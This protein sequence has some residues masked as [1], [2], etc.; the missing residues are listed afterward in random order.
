MSG[1]SIILPEL[2]LLAAALIVLFFPKSAAGSRRAACCAGL[3]TAVALIYNLLMVPVGAQS[4]FGSLLRYDVYS[5]MARSFI[6]A[7]TLIWLIW[8]A[9]RAEAR[10][11]E[12]VSLVLF[13]SLGSLVLT[14]AQDLIMMLVSLE[15]S[16]LPLYVL[17]GYS[18]NSVRGL[19]G[20]LKYFLFSVL[21]TMV[22]L[23][24]L[25]FVYGAAGSTSYA[26][27]A[28]IS[29]NRYM[30]L[31][32][33]LCLV[34]FF[35]KLSAAPFHFWAPDAF[36][37]ASSWIVAFVST[38]PKIS[39][40]VALIRFVMAFDTFM[41]PQL[42]W[43]IAAVASVSMVIGNLAALKQE[44]LKRMMA[45]S[46]IAH[47]GY[48]LLAV[49][50]LNNYVGAALIYIVVYSV[51]TL[52]IMLI[53]QE[54][55][56]TLEHFKGLAKSRPAT[57]WAMVVMLCSLIGIP[58]LAGFFGKLYLF[59]GALQAN[60]LV[61]VVLALIMS[62]V[63]CVYYLRVVYVMFFEQAADDPKSKLA[64][65]YDERA[66]LPF[67]EDL[68]TSGFATTR[69]SFLSSLA[70]TI[71]VLGTVALGLGVS[72]LTAVVM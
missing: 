15:L 25:S 14:G 60:L 4:P 27:F 57:A 59:V 65:A 52:G 6:L 16:A 1:Y 17:M 18:R 20:A 28:N 39:G 45:Y 37:G 44:N 46:S 62:I 12:A 24:G 38:V 42:A 43:L 2:V 70:I 32:I 29:Y 23:Y 56:P 64:L 47:A 13:S 7:F 66:G 63:S 71:C 69:K 34:G 36:T 61:V 22:M 53:A 67:A 41:G 3:A 49:A 19:E 40:V 72:L 10:A 21:T 51:A 55:G 48:L 30:L 58:P 35:A 50:A 31:I 54:V 9:G 26:D 33:G 5:V 8:T 68:P 11:K